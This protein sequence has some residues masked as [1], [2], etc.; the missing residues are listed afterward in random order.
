MPRGSRSR[1]R[2][3][4]RRARRR[5]ARLRRSCAAGTATRAGRRRRGPPRPGARAAA[6]G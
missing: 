5:S 4:A 1:A 3:R 2:R 6:R